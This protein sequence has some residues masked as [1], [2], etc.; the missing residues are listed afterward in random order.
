MKPSKA[1]MKK[2]TAIDMPNTLSSFLMA[3]TGGLRLFN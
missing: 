3:S 1:Q 2:G